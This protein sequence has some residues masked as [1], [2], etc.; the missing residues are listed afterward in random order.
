MPT[1]ACLMVAISGYEISGSSIVEL[2]TTS[3]L[4]LI[5]YPCIAPLKYSTDTAGISISKFTA[6]ALNNEFSVLNRDL[7]V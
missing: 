6:Y 5:P 7:T 2:T 1:H 4:H 3:K